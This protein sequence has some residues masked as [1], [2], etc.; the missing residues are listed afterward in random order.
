MSE[1]PPPVQPPPVGTQPVGLPTGMATAAMILGIVSIVLFCIWYISIPCS[2]IAI[3]LGVV[4][5]KRVAEGTGG[6]KGMATAGIICGVIS[7]GLTLLVIAGVAAFLIKV[8]AISWL[9]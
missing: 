9:A 8:F 3:I 6:G 5:K 1:Q 7:I 4:A 2:I